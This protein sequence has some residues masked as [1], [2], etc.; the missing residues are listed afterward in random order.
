MAE[1]HSD[2]LI[3][4][5]ITD[6]HLRVDGKL[7]NDDKDTEAQLAACVEHLNALQPRPDV[8]LATGDLADEPDETAYEVMRRM[9]EGIEMPVYVIP[10]NHDDREMVR[11]AFLDLGYFP[12]TADGPFLH[13]TVEDHPL[14]LI[15]LD[16]LETG[17]DEGEMC[18]DRRHWLDD[19]LSEQPDR[20][21]LIFMHHQPIMTRMGA[22]DKNAF[23]GAREMEELIRR[24]SQVEWIICGHLHRPIQMRWGG[25]VVSVAPSSAFQRTLTLDNAMPKAFIDEPPGIS[26]HMWSAETGIISHISLMGDFGPPYPMRDG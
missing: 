25:T 3:I 1:Y 17:G 18:A 14:R 26:V 12:T 16:T 9:L 4:A 13:Y 11:R 15:G 22:I 21:T 23:A 6:F 20:P 19:R 2:F 24:H 10:G 8:V 5:Q 7:F